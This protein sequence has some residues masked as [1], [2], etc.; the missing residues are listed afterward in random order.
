MKSKS[1]L[2]QMIWGL[3][4][5]DRAWEQKNVEMLKARSPLLP[6][7]ID[8]TARKLG[9]RFNA[10]QQELRTMNKHGEFDIAAIVLGQKLPDE[11]VVGKLPML[12]EECKALAAVIP[13]Q[14][15]D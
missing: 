1:E 14:F 6:E 12:I 9:M 7:T 11:L 10:V 5:G 2:I 3:S 15:N 4:S 8:A 13:D